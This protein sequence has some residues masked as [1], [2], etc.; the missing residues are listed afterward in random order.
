MFYL[1]IKSVLKIILNIFIL[2]NYFQYKF[3]NRKIINNIKT[4]N[5]KNNISN[6]NIS[7]IIQGEIIYKEDF[8]LNTIIMYLNNFDSCKI[9]L[10][11]WNISNILRSK[12]DKLGVNI[13]INEPPSNP[14]ISNINL[15]ICS[16]VNAILFAEQIGSHYILK[17]RSDQRINN[18]N[19]VDYLLSLLDC[20][21]LN[22]NSKAKQRLVGISLGT[23][24]Y[25]LYGLSDMLLFGSVND[26][27]SYWNVPYDPRLPTSENLAKRGKSWREF[28]L[29]CACEVYLFT[30]YMHYLDLDTNYS[31]NSYL[32]TLGDYFIIV[33]AESIGLFWIKYTLDLDRY[34]QFNII[35]PE[36]NFNDWL[37]FCYYKSRR[38]IDEEVLNNSCL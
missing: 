14:G 20:F 30:N 31:M 10:S 11:T 23:F 26:M 34:S 27:R 15:Q 6:I 22:G 7:I 25:R 18:S 3:F 28:S 4:K 9:I 2:S 32:N 5:F 13:L 21:P 12:L 38:S 36:I 1:K 29:W 35:R 24:K 37:S 19:T 33:D 16:T 8:T 17:T